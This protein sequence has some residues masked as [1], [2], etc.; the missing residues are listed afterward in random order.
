MAESLVSER[1]ALRQAVESG[2]GF[3]DAAETE[4]V[5]RWSLAEVERLREALRDLADDFLA[6]AGEQDAEASG[7]YR[8]AREV[9]GPSGLPVDHPVALAGQ[10]YVALNTEQVG[11]SRDLLAKLVE[12]IGINDD[13]TGPADA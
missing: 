13:Y 9:V 4:R 6:Y 12:S 11:Q 3:R 2:E 10:L 7:Y 5:A 1:E 8:I